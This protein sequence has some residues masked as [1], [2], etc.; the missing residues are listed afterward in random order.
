[1]KH[2]RHKRKESY[3]VLVV[4]NLSRRSRQFRIGRSTLHLLS[5][6]I[7]IVCVGTG[8]LLYQQI[9]RMQRESSLRRQLQEQLLAQ[10]ELTRQWDEEKEQLTEE[11]QELN[12][13]ITTLR[14]DLEL[15]LL[16]QQ[17]QAAGTQTTGKEQNDGQADNPAFPRLY[18]SS[19]TGVL[20][21]TFSEEH[22]YISFTT[23]KGN[24]IIAAGDG[25]VTAVSSDN[26]Y[27][28]IIE[29]SFEGG[30]KSRYL[31]RQRAEVSV[32]E[33]DTVSGG[34]ILLTITSDNTELD[35]QILYTDEPIDPLTVIAAK[36]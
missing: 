19:G 20:T 1:M 15:A 34:D 13:E 29:L 23:E 9:G 12:A 18:P 33:G 10:E 17:I 8:W 3:A 32:S 27:R 30:Y 22:P 6:L 5:V 26:T 11:N 16:E 7:L 25:T 21:A 2:Q 4:S 14:H 28:H 36:G 24:N 35:Y 31:Y